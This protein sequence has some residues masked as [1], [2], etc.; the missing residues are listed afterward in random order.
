MKQNNYVT[1]FIKEIPNDEE[2]QDGILYIAPHY[3][4]AVHKCIADISS[5]WRITIL[6]SCHLC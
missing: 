5:L 4:V 3:A 1:E 2:L 6:L